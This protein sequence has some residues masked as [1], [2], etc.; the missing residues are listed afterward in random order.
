MQLVGKQNP[1]RCPY[2]GGSCMS[3]PGVGQCAPSRRVVPGQGMCP[4]PRLP[5]MGVKP[6]TDKQSLDLETIEQRDELRRNVAYL[7]SLTERRQEVQPVAVER[8]LL[9]PGRRWGD[10]WQTCP[11][12]AQ[13]TP[14]LV[15]KEHPEPRNR[16]VLAC[17]ETIEVQRSLQ[18][19]PATRSWL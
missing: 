5:E 3:A 12:T 14:H 8:R 4:L 15:L 16:A 11:G 13:L 6:M 18:R 9:L 2:G 19:H 10:H 1:H 7:L 17:I